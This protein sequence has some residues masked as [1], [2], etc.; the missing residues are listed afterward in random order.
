MHCA[1]CSEAIVQYIQSEDLLH[2]KQ[3]LKKLKGK[4]KTYESNSTKKLSKTHT[5][6]LR[7]VAALLLLFVCSFFAVKVVKEK[8][9]L[10]EDIHS[11]QAE[12]KKEFRQKSPEQPT[13]Q[14]GLSESSR[15]PKPHALA[16]GN[17]PA[18]KVQH[19]AQTPVASA[20]Q[21]EAKESKRTA[22]PPQGKKTTPASTSPT[23]V[24]PQ[25]QQPVTT[26]SSDAEEAAPAEK[27]EKREE[28]NIP[29]PL[30]AIEKLDIQPSDTPPVNEQKAPSLPVTGS[31]GF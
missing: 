6:M 26:P 7:A 21:K 11:A 24:A 14:E 19:A 27:E 15:E 28:Q 2:A 1:Q 4:L 17:V 9:S 20:D 30:P 16:I 25:L 23:V 8:N 29:K 22:V 5:K 10:K 13:T 18:K 12:K 3:H 31:T